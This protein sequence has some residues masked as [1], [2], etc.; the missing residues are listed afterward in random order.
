MTQIN[1]SGQ[2]ATTEADA[3]PLIPQEVASEIVNGI[4][5]ASAVLSLFRRLPNMSSR[6]LRMPVLNS[7]GAANFIAGTVNDDLTLGA[8]NEAPDSVAED[9]IPGLKSTHQMEWT[10]VYI[11]AEPLAI[12]LPIGEDVLED[13]Q[14]P[15][16]DEIRPRI[17]EAFGIAI[18][19]AV[20]WGQGRPASWPSGIVPT[21]ISRGFTY[22]EGAGTA[23]VDST[24]EAMGLLEAVGYNP[25]GWI[26]DPVAKKDLRSLTDTMGRPLFVP[27]LTQGEPSTLWGLPIEYVRNGTMRRATTR[28]IVGDMNQAVYSIRTDMRFDIFREGVITDSNGVVVANLMQN[29]MVALRV[30]MRLGWAVPNPIHAMGT[31][32]SE[33]YPF[34][35]LTA[36]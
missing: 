26:I 36:A 14:Y 17:V 18:D 15:I 2:F 34:A 31:D 7:M 13:S 33:K 22:A 21:A 27:S 16:W 5:E 23:L 9:G 19:N 35:I 4:T 32:R 8:D 10:N 20:I 1:T 6:T 24:S 28:F 30:V 3:L 25:N 11:H 29:D 12:I